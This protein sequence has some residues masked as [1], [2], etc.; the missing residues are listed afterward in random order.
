V[1][2]GLPQ[3]GWW[4]DPAAYDNV[5]YFLGISTQPQA[6]GGVAHIGYLAVLAYDPS[7]RQVW[8]TAQATLAADLSFTGT[9]TQYAGGAP[10]GSAVAATATSGTAVGQVRMTFD[11]T[12]RARITLPSGGSTT[13]PRFGL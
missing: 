6:D 8:Q 2:P 11:G 7:G 10:F 5:G 9:L 3:S 4:Y 1:Q 13:L 12:D